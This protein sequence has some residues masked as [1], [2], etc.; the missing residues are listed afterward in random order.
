MINYNEKEA[1]NQNRSQRYGI[2]RSRLRHGHK[3]AKYKMCLSM[4]IVICIKQ[5]LSNI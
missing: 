2:N 4:M 5:Q 3:Y 1:E